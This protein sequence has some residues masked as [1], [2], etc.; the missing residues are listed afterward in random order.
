MLSCATASVW[1]L[2]WAPCLIPVPVCSPPFLRY[3]MYMGEAGRLVSVHSQSSAIGFVQYC[4]NQ[5]FHLQRIFLNS[6]P[7]CDLNCQQALSF[8]TTYMY[9]L[10]TILV[11][12]MTEYDIRHS[13]SQVH[14]PWH[15]SWQSITDM[16]HM[17]QS[18]VEI[19]HYSVVSHYCVRSALAPN[20]C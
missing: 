13:I 2:Y 11:Q 10:C 9:L 19:E 17:W 4:H 6:S 1:V 15:F 5:C 3:A 20:F 8:P 7:A 12:V 16:W 14:I 18:R